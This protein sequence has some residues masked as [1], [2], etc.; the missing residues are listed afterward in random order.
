MHKIHVLMVVNV[1]RIILADSH[2]V[3][4]IHLLVNVVKIV[5]SYNYMK[6]SNY[7]SCSTGIDPCISQPCQNGGTCQPFNGNSYQC[8]CPPGYSGYDCS[9]RKCLIF[10]ENE[11][12][13]D[14]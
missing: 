3:V 2:V 12:N 6:Y 5:S 1:R 13:S 4:R 14:A 7:H 10:H 8:I 11:K 9:T